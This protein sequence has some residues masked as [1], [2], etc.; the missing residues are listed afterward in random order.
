MDDSDVNCARIK[1]NLHIRNDKY[2]S[3]QHDE[4]KWH[5]KYKHVISIYKI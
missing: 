4:E 1:V 3:E 2:L 5:E